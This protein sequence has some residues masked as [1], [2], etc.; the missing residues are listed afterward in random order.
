MTTQA[1]AVLGSAGAIVNDKQTQASI[2][3][4]LPDGVEGARLMQ[5][6]KRAVEEAYAGSPK[7]WAGV[8]ASSL[9]QTLL[10]CAR[11]GLWPGPHGHVYLVP[12][13]GEAQA[14]LGYKGMI[15]L[16]KRSAGVVRVAAHLRQERDA[17]AYSLGTAPKIEHTPA[18]GDRGPVVGAYAIAWF[19]DGSWQAEYMDMDEIIAVKNGSPSSKAALSP[20]NHPEHKLQMARKCPLR[21]LFKYVGLDETLGHALEMDDREF[22]AR[23]VTPAPAIAA[24][25]S[26]AAMAAAFALTPP[27][28]TVAL[29]HDA[30]TGEVP[31]QPSADDI[32]EMRAREL[33]MEVGS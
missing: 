26:P 7:M 25:T 6:W 1:P 13:K 21:R 3:R 2:K 14:Q 12:Y 29:A 22:R 19:A 11:V 15:T 8:S 16:M 18:E 24:G 17:W 28:A 32:A 30:E 31:W 10:D 33:E 9:T 5:A 23:D 4:L 20:W 27:P